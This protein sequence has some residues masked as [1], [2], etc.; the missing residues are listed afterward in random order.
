MI[1]DRHDLGKFETLRTEQFQC[2]V[3]PG[4]QP[5][6]E[7][8]LAE[9]PPAEWT[10]WQE[11]KRSTV[12]T[13]YQGSIRGPGGDPVDTHLKLFRAVRLSDRARDAVGGSR[14]A[15]EFHNLTGAR[16]RGLPCVQPVAAGSI[17][18]SLGSQSFLLTRTELGEPLPRGPL[19]AEDA[20]RVGRLLR[21]CHDAG[22]HAR[23]LHPGNIL[24]KPDGELVLV[25]LTSAVLADRLLAKDRGRALAFFCLDLEAGVEDAAARPLLQAYGANPVTLDAARKSS[26]RL[27]NRALS[28]FGRRAFRAC[29]T[30]QIERDKRQPRVYLHTPARSMWG[31]A[32]S[33]IESLDK[34]DPVKSGRRGAVYLE[35]QLAIK[36]RSAA[37]AR[38]LFESAYWLRFAGVPTPM[39][40]ALQTFRSAGTIAVQR[41]PWP[42]LLAESRSL[43]QAELLRAAGSL[44]DSVGRLHSYGLRNRD[45]KLENLVRD[46]GSGTVYMVDLDGIKRRVPTESRGRSADLGRLLAAFWRADQPG[47]AQVIR[48]FLSAYLRSCKR[49]LYPIAH[50]RHLLAQAVTRATEKCG[51]DY[52]S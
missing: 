7:Q 31:E 46:P 13:I 30:T 50:R 41:L 1:P 42:D 8:L 51:V 2:L 36:V 14:S 24:R 20:R 49:L 15:R 34:L 5:C 52:L 22:L 16:E 21:E 9:H 27:R 35:E 39:P 32:R 18:G 4:W 11:I 44:G 10:Q 40:I 23:D 26:R 12:R 38:R 48:A 37:A 33:Q 47:G 43:T 29:K 19:P 25:D 28:S 17:V 3:D 45:L 6:L